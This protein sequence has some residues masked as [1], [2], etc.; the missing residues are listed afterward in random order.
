MASRDAELLANPRSNLSII[1]FPSRRFDSLMQICAIDI[2]K[3]SCFRLHS[4]YCIKPSDPETRT[5][6]V[7]EDS[8]LMP[9]SSFNLFRSFFFVSN[10]SL[11]DRTKTVLNIQKRK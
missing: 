2:C 7:S 4:G 9:N 11:V 6:E 3:H 8:P 10:P 1:K 5:Y